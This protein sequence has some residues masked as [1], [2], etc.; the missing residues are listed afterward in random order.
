[1]ID[2]R[3]QEPKGAEEAYSGS[4]NT[5]PASESTFSRDRR[6]SAWLTDSSSRFSLL[7]LIFNPWRCRHGGDN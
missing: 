3:I 6:F 5:E 2:V 7:D 1:M 4:D